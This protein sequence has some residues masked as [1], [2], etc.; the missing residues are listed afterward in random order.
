MSSSKPSKTKCENN[1]D[2]SRIESSSLPHLLLIGD[3][4]IK[5]WPSRLRPI[6]PRTDNT[7]DGSNQP[8]FNGD[9][10]RNKTYSNIHVC[11]RDGATIRDCIQVAYKFFKYHNTSTGRY[12]YPLIVIACAGENDLGHGLSVDNIIETFDEFIRTVL[13]RSSSSSASIKQLEISTVTPKAPS[14]NVPKTYL[15]FLGPKLEPWLQDDPNSRKEYVKLSQK[16]QK[17]VDELS[18]SISSHSHAVFLDCLTMFC[19]A[20]SSLP[21]AI[22]GGR[23]IAEVKYFDEDKLH[24][25]ESGYTVWKNLV[26]KELIK[27]MHSLK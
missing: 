8:S 24:L 17:K 7:E 6:L 16:M 20:S 21:G 18:T 19:G 25:N 1:F 10:S 23:A 26:E 13:N 9:K 15:F 4:D 5:R 27:V 14:M 22:Y 3:S 12:N 11:G 2:P